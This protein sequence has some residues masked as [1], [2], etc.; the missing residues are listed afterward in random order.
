[1]IHGSVSH[2]LLQRI[3]LS[4]VVMI[5]NLSHN[6]MGWWSKGEVLLTTLELLEL[7][8]LC[9]RPNENKFTFSAGWLFKQKKYMFVIHF[10]KQFKQYRD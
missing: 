7:Y 6:I 3:S 5:I 8:S 10:S 2:T 1:M 4:L 9:W